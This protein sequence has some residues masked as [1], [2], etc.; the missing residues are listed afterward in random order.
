[1][2]QGKLTQGID[3]QVG[4]TTG[5]GGRQHLML[6]CQNVTLIAG[7]L[8]L[9]VVVLASL[10]AW[11]AQQLLF[12]GQPQDFPTTLGL[13][14]VNSLAFVYV[15]R[16]RG[17][18]RIPVL[19]APSRYIS[20]LFISWALV[21][22]LYAA[23]LL[24]LRSDAEVLRGTMA[25]A[26]GLQIALLLLVRLL[27]EKVFR[28]MMASG[29]LAGRRVVTIGEPAELCRLG[30]AMLFRY[31]GLKEVARVVVTH[32]RARPVEEVLIQ[33]D[34]AMQEARDH[35]AEEFII[36]MG[37]NSKELL[38]TIR[39]R[40]RASPLPAHL[41]PDYTIRSMLGRRIL[42]TS[43]SNL[44]LEIQRAPLSLSERA[45]KRAVDILMSASAIV[46][47]LPL[48]LLVAVAV[49]L[50]S[51][52]PV[53]FK[54]RRNGFNANQFVI[55]KFRSMTVL[56]DGPSITQAYPGDK[57][58]TRVG[59]LLRSSSI[60]ELPQLFNVLKGDMSIVGPRPHALAHDDEYKAIIAE[61]AFRHHVKPG[62]T[63]WAQVNGFRGET[64]HVE[65]MA[66]RIKL[67]L[68][69]INHWSLRLDVAIILRTCFEVLRN[70]AY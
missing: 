58:V 32:D 33:L 45:V 43:G 11:K 2:Y 14:F 49:K 19:L 69:Y 37:W 10:V 3:A 27:T 52:G 46:L 54:Q 8:D 15:A 22:L 4:T 41:L 39:D 35:R 16:S 12:A 66:Q 50:D 13:A 36:A 48:F 20:R 9:V 68:Y 67:D 26:A 55:Y 65:L 62:I 21:T 7:L 5:T 29:S 64:R 70:R 63:G 42:S 34:R 17:L 57:R 56:E 47:L 53:I 40:L 60:D 6:S 30:K 23:F 38:E 18:Y 28:S 31:F 59:K 44:T 51:R 24:L 25:I 61:Y 1:M